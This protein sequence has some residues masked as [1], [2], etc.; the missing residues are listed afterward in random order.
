VNPSTASAH[1][2]GRLATLLLDPF[3]AQRWLVRR[4]DS[5]ALSLT[6]R[7]RD[8]RLERLG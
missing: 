5:R 7:G 2:A 6:S 1:L 4:K 8:C 3:L